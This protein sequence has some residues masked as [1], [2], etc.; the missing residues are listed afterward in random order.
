MQI[1]LPIWKCIIATTPEGNTSFGQAALATLNDLGVVAE[2]FLNYL[3][4]ADTISYADNTKNNFVSLADPLY[5]TGPR[6]NFSIDFA[7]VAKDRALFRVTLLLSFSIKT[8]MLPARLHKHLHI[9]LV[10]HRTP[11]KMSYKCPRKADFDCFCNLPL[12]QDVCS[13]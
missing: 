12:L 2:H 13:N 1:G 11:F 9:L 5:P 6:L 10:N 3:N 4:N 8:L 7:S